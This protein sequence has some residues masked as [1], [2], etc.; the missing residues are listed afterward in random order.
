[1]MKK[2]AGSALGLTLAPHLT[3][4]EDMGASGALKG[5]IHHS[6]CRWCY[7]GIPL[8]TLAKAAADMGIES[9]ELLTPDEFETVRKH[10]LTCAMVSSINKDW[11]IERGWNKSAHHKGL[12]DWYKHLIDETSKV[13]FKNLICFSGNREEDLSDEEGLENCMTG[14]QKIIPYAEKKKVTLVMELLNSKIDHH[15]YM[16][17][18][19]DWGAEL[20]R[21]V[22]S[23]NLKLLYDIYHMQI[24]EGDVIRTIKENHHFF[25]H[26]HTGGVPDRHEIDDTQELFYPVIMKTIV[27]TGY[28]GFVGQE[29]IPKKDDKLAALNQGV[30]ICDV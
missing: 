14:L 11:G 12:I 19:T 21:M 3:M 23:D 26:Y 5:N 20:C 4:A 1:M 30:L 9:V 22:D 7:D 8:E 27:A 29:F 13:G 18:F 15:N 6:V 10:G 2:L 16:C 17:D 28:K 24:M 25:A